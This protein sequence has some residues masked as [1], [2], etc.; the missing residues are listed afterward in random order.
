M[1]SKVPE[2]VWE[3]HIDKSVDISDLNQNFGALGLSKV[4]FR[5]L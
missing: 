5:E 2:S 1:G 4:N 3:R